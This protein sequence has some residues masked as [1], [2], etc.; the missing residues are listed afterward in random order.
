VRRCRHALTCELCGQFSCYSF[1]SSLYKRERKSSGRRCR[2]ARTYE[3]CGQGQPER[4]RESG[5]PLSACAHVRA[6]RWVQ[7]FFFLQK[8][9]RAR[10]SCTPLSAHL[11][12]CLSGQISLY[13]SSLFRTR[14]ACA[15]ALTCE[16]S[17]QVSYYISAVPLE[18]E[19]H[20]RLR[21]LAS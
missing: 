8:S 1:L 7:L 16:L 6:L 4:A 18:L 14:E 17:S 5:A 9:L 13:F 19:R 3:L 12:A 21:S 10:E 20:L 11:Q 15:H 2:H